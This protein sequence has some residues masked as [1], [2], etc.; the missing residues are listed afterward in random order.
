MAS[1]W[2]SAVSYI[3]PANARSQ[4]LAARLGAVRDLTAANP[5]GDATQVWRHGRGVIA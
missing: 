1:G 2:T 5:Y 4:T 3:D